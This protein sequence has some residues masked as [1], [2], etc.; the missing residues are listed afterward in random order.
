M[1]P[2]RLADGQPSDGLTQRAIALNEGSLQPVDNGSAPIMK[3]PGRAVDSMTARAGPVGYLRR[4]AIADVSG[5][6]GKI[7]E[8]KARIGDEAGGGC[9]QMHERG[10]A[11]QGHG[12]QGNIFHEVRGM[13][14]DGPRG[15]GYAK[16]RWQSQTTRPDSDKCL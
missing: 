14:G 3:R 5:R 1:N 2:I 6:H 7:I 10:Q 12:A 11:Q 15:L 8:F 9:R 13:R 4:V 16:N